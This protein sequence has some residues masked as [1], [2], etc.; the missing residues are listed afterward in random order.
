MPKNKRDKQNLDFIKD[1]MTTEEI[2]DTIDN[3]RKEYNFDIITDNEKTIL[4]K[5]YEFFSKRYPMLFDTIIEPIYDQNRLL[6][7]LNMRDKIVNN[8]KT[9]E[10]ASKD[11]GNVMFKEYVKDKY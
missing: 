10:D 1:G 5:K 9:F 8:E 6:M 4:K 2:I 3:I 7:F 11:I